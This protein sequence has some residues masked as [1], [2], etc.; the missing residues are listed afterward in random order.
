M[1]LP[2]NRNPYLSVAEAA[3]IAGLSDGRMRQLLI[4][5][6]IEG[7]KLNARA[8]AVSRKSVEDFAKI[9]QHMGRPRKGR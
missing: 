5:G 6:I 3:E 4:N 7:I 9:P 1:S 2:A 8:W